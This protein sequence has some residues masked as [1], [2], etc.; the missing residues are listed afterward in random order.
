MWRTVSGWLPRVSRPKPIED[1]F[2]AVRAEIDRVCRGITLRV[3]P[4]PPAIPIPGDFGPLARVGIAR[5]PDELESLLGSPAYGLGPQCP[6]C[7]NT[8]EGHQRLRGSLQP[9]FVSGPSFL[10]PV[11]IHPT[12]LE[13]CPDTGEQRG[14][15]W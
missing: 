6:V 11:W 5:D 10:M 9:E 4:R 3:L 14:V 7:G 15:P 12:C 1:P 8:T 13:A 2:D